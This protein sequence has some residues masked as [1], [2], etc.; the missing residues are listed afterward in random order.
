MRQTLVHHATKHQQILRFLVTGS[1]AFTVNITVLY[2]LTSILHI[3]YLLSTVLAFLASFSV[4][5]CMQK[6]WTFK[7]H[8][9]DRWHAQFSLYLTLQLINLILNAGLMYV[10]VEYL[11]IWYIFSQTIIALVLAIT[12]F[13]I[14]KFY[15][16]KPQ[17]A[18]P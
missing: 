11:H 13:F 6:F 2:S 7:D 15:I 4:S 5:F 9:S 16:F 1:I 12:S 14:N 3:Y 17:S 18:A 10:F 8:S